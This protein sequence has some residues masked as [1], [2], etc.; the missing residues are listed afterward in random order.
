[1][2]ILRRQFLLFAGM[3]AALP[4]LP[5]VGRAQTFPT[6][7]VHM[8]VG[9]PAGGTTDVVARLMGQWLAERLGGSFVVENR[10]GAAT[11]IATESVVR[12]APDGYTLLVCVGTNTI[13]AS[14]YD[15]LNF[16]FI[17]DI[18]MVGGIVRHPLV[19]EVH[20]DVPVKTVPEFI[21]YAKAN[22]SKISMASFG[23]GTIS[24]VTGELF[25]LT[26]GTQMTHVPYRGSAPMLT[27]LLSGRVQMA[28]DALPASIAHIKAGKLRALAVTTAMRS[29]AL[30]GVTTVGEFLPGF[31]VNAF[32]ALCAPKN[33]P[34]D[35]IEKLNTEINAA[36]SD[37][38]IK[39]R[40]NELGG[41]PFPGSAA[42]LTKYVADETE[43]WG[44][45]IRAANIKAE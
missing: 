36:F 33:T 32:V 13:N 2:T 28:F 20:P 7:T 16:N 14:L 21:D 34:P 11:N 37:P 35:I 6:R 38:T 25:K 23:T 19:M 45:V 17:R 10:P 42:A 44:K 22:P 29:P 3:T 24:H 12:A 8:I 40:I 4:A 18:A 27:D 39:A 9:F 5:R 31:E 15:N 30:P 26:T 43:K 1:M 41:M